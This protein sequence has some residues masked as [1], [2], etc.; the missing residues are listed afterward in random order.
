MT[1]CTPL[2]GPNDIDFTSDEY[3]GLVMALAPKILPRVHRINALGWRNGVRIPMA[4]CG[5]T[6]VRNVLRRFGSSIAEE[7]FG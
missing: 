5:E 6:R 4:L 1:T 3:C 7:I 2:P